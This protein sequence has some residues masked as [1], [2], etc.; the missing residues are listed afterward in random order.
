MEKCGQ[1]Q[2]KG[3]TWMMMRAAGKSLLGR[4]PTEVYGEHRHTSTSF[5]RRGNHGGPERADER[6]RQRYDQ[7]QQERRYPGAAENPVKPIGA[8]VS[9]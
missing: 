2:D 5:A 3:D 7:R 6:T 1:A 8:S 4:P 9:L